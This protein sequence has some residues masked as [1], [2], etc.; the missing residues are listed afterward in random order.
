MDF[1]ID[2]WRFSEDQAVQPD[3]KPQ[4]IEPG[5]WYHCQRDAA[6]V[7]EWLVSNA[8]PASI[9][10]SLLAE[11]TRP[12]FEQYDDQNFLL[13]L[14]GVNLNENADPADMLSVRILYYNS[15]LISSRKIPSKTINTLRNALLEG[16]G[17]KSLAELVLGIVDGLN[18]NIDSYLDLVE[19]KITAFDDETELSEE[20]MNTHKALL[21]IKRF[22]KPQQYAIDDYQNS[23]VPLASNKHLRLRHSVNTITRINETL[24]FYLSELEI[25][26][27]EL[28][29]YHAE[30]MNQNTYLFSVI[31]AIFLPTSFLTGLLGVNVGGIPGTESP[32]AFGVFCL[33]L[34]AIFGLEF[35]I[36]RRLQFFSKQP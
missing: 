29:Q 21:K 6:G 8:I 18:R 22:I 15:A 28:R 11:D 3:G 23:S 26:K 2:H 10:D 7:R 9:V 32:V 13:I 33:G 12:L 24:D 30:K 27:G 35:W 16:N 36:L 31:A 19:D 20:L 34:V 14:R 25:I 5:H 4:N 1:L 17:P